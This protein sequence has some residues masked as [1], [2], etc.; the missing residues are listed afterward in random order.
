[1]SESTR[2]TNTSQDGDKTIWYINPVG[3]KS[4]AFVPVHGIPMTFTFHDKGKDAGAIT[5]ARGERHIEIEGDNRVS[6]IW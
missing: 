5:S 1:M 2:T 6:S 3:E 4:C